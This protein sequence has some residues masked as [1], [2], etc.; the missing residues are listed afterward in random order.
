MANIPHSPASTPFI[1]FSVVYVLGSSSRI[2]P[3]RLIKHIQIDMSGLLSNSYSHT[4]LPVI[5]VAHPINLI[6]L[7]F[8]HMDGHIG[9]NHGYIHQ[10][11]DWL[12]HKIAYYMCVVRFTN[13]LFY[14]SPP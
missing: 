13:L 14:T 11:S 8:L 6:Y 4:A 5:P 9:C 1:R 7:F 12:A 10:K 3:I 2:C